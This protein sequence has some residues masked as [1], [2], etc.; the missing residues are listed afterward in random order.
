MG[1]GSGA[2]GEDEWVLVFLTACQAVVAGCNRQTR[3]S[4]PF[5]TSCAHSAVIGMKSELL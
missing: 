4:F 3:L 2:V 5:R 1:G